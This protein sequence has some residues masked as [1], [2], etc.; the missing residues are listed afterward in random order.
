MIGRAVRD[1]KRTSL[2]ARAELTQIELQSRAQNEPAINVD[3]EHPES[4]ELSGQRNTGRTA[5][6][7][8]REPRPELFAVGKDHRG[9]LFS[10]ALG[11]L[12]Q[13]RTIK[14]RIGELLPP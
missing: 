7:H 5:S 14:P 4:L 13:F 8:Q 2:S 6:L 3:E 11:P 9:R 10:A 1:P 12:P